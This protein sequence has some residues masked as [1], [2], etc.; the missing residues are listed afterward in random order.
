MIS[1]A[2]E[3]TEILWAK[4]Y[5]KKK[6]EEYKDFKWKSNELKEIRTMIIKTKSFSLK[7]TLNEAH[8]KKNI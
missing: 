4:T 2:K 3:R 7:L 6:K 5:K 1:S 8:I